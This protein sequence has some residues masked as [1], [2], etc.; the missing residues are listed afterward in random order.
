[1]NP[2]SGDALH[3]MSGK[4]RS[5]SQRRSLRSGSQSQRSG[6]VRDREWDDEEALKWAALEKLPTYNRLRTAILKDVAEQGPGV[7]AKRHEVDVT[8]LGLQDKRA[9]IESLI[10]VID[11][12]NERF[13][14]ILRTRLDS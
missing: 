4:W 14:R 10:R 5:M 3:S 11:E 12:D 13:Q 1:M 6:S 7:R 8:K 9:M 2:I